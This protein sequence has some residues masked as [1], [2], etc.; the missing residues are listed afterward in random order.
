MSALAGSIIS[1]ILESYILVGIFIYLITAGVLFGIGILSSGFL[2]RFIAPSVYSLLCESLLFGFLITPC[3]FVTSDTISILPIPVALAFNSSI[4][5]NILGG[6]IAVLCTF[7]II[8]AI[9][10][11]LLVLR[12]KNDVKS[13]R[14]GSR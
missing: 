11:L 1:M 13:L 6:M 7:I 12:N 2:R 14:G 4:G 8:T 9:S 3:I 5:G 10:L